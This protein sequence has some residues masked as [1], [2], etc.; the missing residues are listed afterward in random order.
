LIV[1]VDSRLF[2]DG[3]NSDDA[4]GSCGV[5]NRCVAAFPQNGMWKKLRRIGEFRDVSRCNI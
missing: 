2:D 3:V 1:S 4:I 5:G